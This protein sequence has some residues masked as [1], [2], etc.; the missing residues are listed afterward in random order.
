MLT[1]RAIN[2]GNLGVIIPQIEP[3]TKTINIVIP[4]SFQFGRESIQTIT[5]PSINAIRI[6]ITNLLFIQK[7]LNIP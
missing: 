7:T 5:S 6:V 1:S 4:V 2:H 3:A